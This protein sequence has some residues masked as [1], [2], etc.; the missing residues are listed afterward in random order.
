MTTYKWLKEHLSNM[1]CPCDRH[2]T[3]THGYVSRPTYYSW[4][5]VRDRVVKYNDSF[6]YELWNTTIFEAK[7]HKQCK[8]MMVLSYTFYP[9]YASATTRNR[10]NMIAMILD[11]PVRFSLKDDCLYADDMKC[12]FVQVYPG[13]G[14]IIYHVHGMNMETESRDDYQVTKIYDKK[15]DMI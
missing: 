4:V 1:F 9:C 2:I 8:D 14:E 6:D 15:G 3:Y 7:Y 13:I 12:D 10:L 5:G 11:I